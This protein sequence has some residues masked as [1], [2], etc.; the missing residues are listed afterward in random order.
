MIEPTPPRSQAWSSTTK[1]VVA[2]TFVAAV[3][4]LLIKFS[5]VLGPLLI[6]LILAY[7]FKPV[8]DILQQRGLS[9]GISVTIIYLVILLLIIGL[10]TWGGVG[11]VQQ[12]QS[13]V[14][15]IQK[16][17][18]GLP[19]LIQ[20]LSGRVFQVGPFRLDFSKTDLNALSGEVLGMIQPLLSRTGVL[21]S[22]VA[23]E[24]ASFVGWM[25]FVLLV[26]YFILVESGGLRNQLIKFDVPY[27]REDIARLTLELGRIWNAFLRGQLII[28][29][30]T[31]IVY[32]IVLG[33]LGVHYAFGIAILAGLARFVPYVG[34]AVNWLILFL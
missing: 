13:L 8:A 32:T 31:V 33:I 9:W 10:A 4:A 29:V 17:L 34:P 2:L 12:I 7:L 28:F 6:A 16:G 23:A 20:D 25:L 22:A 30:M 21:L 24:A 14:D 5:F 27:Y 26:S 11:L 15:L 18:E 1:L 3:A 19:G